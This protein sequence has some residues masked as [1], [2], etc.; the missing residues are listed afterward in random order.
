MKKVV[1]VNSSDECK[2]ASV[3]LAFFCNLYQRHSCLF[4]CF[5]HIF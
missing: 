1:S 4:A 2:K 5:A 3:W